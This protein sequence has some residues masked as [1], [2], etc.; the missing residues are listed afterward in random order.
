MAKRQVQEL[1]FLSQVLMAPVVALATGLKDPKRARTLESADVDK[2]LEMSFESAK[3]IPRVPRDFRGPARRRAFRKNWAGASKRS[4]TR[5]W[6]CSKMGS[7]RREA[8]S[9]FARKAVDLPRIRL[10][11]FVSQYPTLPVAPPSTCL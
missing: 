1:Q 4:H 2:L 7:S 10:T 6:G 3:A 9:S 8:R 11:S 5:G